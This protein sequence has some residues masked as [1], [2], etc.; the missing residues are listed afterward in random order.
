MG[1]GINI[2]Y[3][4]HPKKSFDE[5]MSTYS[6]VYFFLDDILKDKESFEEVYQDLLDLLK[7]K[8]EDKEIRTMPIQFYIHHGD[9]K[10]AGKKKNL[11]SL[12]IRHF[13]S[14]LILWYAFMECDCYDIMDGSFIFNFKNASLD[15]ITNY[16]D[17]MIL[18]NLT[19]ID[20]NTQSRIIDE[21]THHMTAISRA[22]SPIF[23]LGVSIYSIIQA[24]KR[25][26]RIGELMHEKLDPNLQP[27]E[28]EAELN[29]RTSE[30]IDLF[31]QD[32]DNDLKP[33]FQSGNNLSKGQ[34]KE[35]AIMI[36]LKS[37]INGSTVPHLIDK[38]ILVDGLNSPSAYYLDAMSGRKS[39]IMSKTKMGEP[40]AFSKKATTATTA[41][42]LRRDYLMCHTSKP[43]TYHINDDKFLRML[44]RRYYYDEN[45]ELKMLNYK[46]DKDLIGHDVMF[47]SPC[48]CASRDGICAYCY[49]G[50]FDLN[51]DLYSAGAYAAMKV[52][53]PLGQRVLSSKHLQMTHSDPIVMSP[54]FAEQ[55]E[56]YSNDITVKSNAESDEELFIQIPDIQKEETEDTVDYY[57][58]S[59]NVIDFSGKILYP[60]KEESGAKLY[61]SDQLASIVLK[62]K[63]PHRPI[64]MDIFDDDTSVLFNV[65]VKSQELTR[66][67][68]NINRLLNTNDRMGCETIDDV[69]QTMAEQQ[70][71]AGIDYNFVHME[72]LVRALIRKRSNVYEDPDFGPNGDPDDYVILRLNDALFKNPSPTVSL[73]YGYLKKQ[74]LSPE[75]YEKTAVSH[76]DPLFVSKVSSII[77]DD[78]D[79]A[80]NAVLV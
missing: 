51:K 78:D 31:V 38:N 64:S 30:L 2:D 14:N 20:F 37:D 23:G 18:P 11:H 22:F 65:E 67:I 1:A 75:F 10:G 27:V 63:D 53:E 73:S 13:L 42:Q 12:Q 56:L 15:D 43:I 76:L 62:Q 52:T 60:V 34:F 59:F 28:I 33:L 68:K 17:D 41:V 35:I 9:E 71:E 8:F 32:E 50:L 48:T 80:N 46:K 16:I 6:N 19:D 29:K 70:L 36:G 74:L 25:N 61:L 66:P 54:Q 72:M 40:G 44:D 26:P 45:G 55:F 7:Y 58:T 24:D 3:D 21:I 69:L 39:L 4:G 49:G 77:P 5:L 79:E 47:R 57:C